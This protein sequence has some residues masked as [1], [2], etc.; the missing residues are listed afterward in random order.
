MNN[1]QAR[2]NARQANGRF[3][4]YAKDTPTRIPLTGADIQHESMLPT[5]EVPVTAVRPGDRIVM[6]GV[7]IRNVTT[8]VSQ[9]PSGNWVIH[10]DS[11]HYEDPQF[12]SDKATVRVINE[13]HPRAIGLKGLQTGRPTDVIAGIEAMSKVITP[14]NASFELYADYSRFT[15]PPV[16]PS[17]LKP[18]QVEH[19]TELLEQMAR[20]DYYRSFPPA[21]GNPLNLFRNARTPMEAEVIW[22][23][24]TSPENISADGM[25]SHADVNR[26]YAR[27]EAE[28]KARLSEIISEY[29]FMG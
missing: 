13:D 8:G 11:E 1:D 24:L 28:Y 15:P 21:P 29:A 26:S 25:R 7:E 6:M 20:E 10:T 18:E 27:Y 2:E 9:E 3:G 19:A 14:Q 5:V 16:P 22:D 23:G 12:T 4:E 17:Q